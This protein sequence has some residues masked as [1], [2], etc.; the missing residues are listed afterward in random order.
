MQNKKITGIKGY[1]TYLGGGE[2]L[3]QAC[4]FSCSLTEVDM[5]GMVDSAVDTVVDMVEDTEVVDKAIVA[6]VD[7]G[8]IW[9]N[10]H[11]VPR[12]K[13]CPVSTTALLEI[14]ELGLLCDVVESL[15]TGAQCT[16]LAI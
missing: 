10:W 8:N 7:T 11:V 12:I 3:P 9:W 6:A 13:T 5:V 16:K 4:P 1:S 2:N 15:M 14:L